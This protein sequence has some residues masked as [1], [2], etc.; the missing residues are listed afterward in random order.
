MLKSTQTIIDNDLHHHLIRDRDLSALF[1]GSDARRYALVNKGLKQGELIRLTRG[2]YILNN[3]YLNSLFSKPYLANRLLAHS[4]VSAESALSFHGWIP[5]RVS[6]TVSIC[7]FGRSRAFDT[8]IGRFCYHTIPVDPAHFYT[9]VELLSEN[10]HYLYIA[11]PPRAILDLIYLNKINNANMAYLID[12]LRIDEE[13][14]MK[15]NKKD[16]AALLPV[17][18]SKRIKQF[19]NQLMNEIANE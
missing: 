2:N 3:R 9:G 14:L 16:I 19:V 15:I 1:G 4:F 7:A 10:K 12:G 8:P 5:E 6:E 13:P 18:R 17:Y 11:S